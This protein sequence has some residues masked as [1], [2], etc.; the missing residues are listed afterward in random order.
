MIAHKTHHKAMENNHI[1]MECH[2]DITM[3]PIMTSEVILTSH[4]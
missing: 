2:Y 3:E 4:K 1:T